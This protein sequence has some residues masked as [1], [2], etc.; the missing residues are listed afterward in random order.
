MEDHGNGNQY[1]W[2]AS[3]EVPR[4]KKGSRKANAEVRNDEQNASSV[5]DYGGASGGD[6]YGSIAGSRQSRSYWSAGWRTRD[7]PVAAQNSG[8]ASGRITPKI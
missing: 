3:I 2:L 7:L 5:V 6:G 8:G 1:G 4:P